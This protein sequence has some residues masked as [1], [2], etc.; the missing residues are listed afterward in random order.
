MCFRYSRVMELKSYRVRPYPGTYHVP[1][2]RTSSGT[3]AGAI[4]PCSLLF[5][6]LKERG[7]T[8]V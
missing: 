3:H 5:G 7:D 6:T 1:Y 2:I 4:Q 8:T